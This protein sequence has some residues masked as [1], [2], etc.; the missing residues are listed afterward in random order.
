M[1]PC[2]DRLAWL[3]TPMALDLALATGP[4]G[5][6]YDV[7][8]DLASFAGA[9]PALRQRQD[10]ALSAAA[11][12]FTGGRSLQRSIASRRPDAHCFPS[13]VEVEHYAP[14]RAWRRPRPRPVAGYVGVVDE[15]LDPALLGE[16]A[17]CLPDWDLEVVGPVLKIDEA[18]LPTAP[19][20]RY[21]GPCAYADLPRVM[22]GFDVALMPF[23]S[24]E[25][26][27][28]ISP[29]KTLEYLAAGLPVVS[30]KVPD[31][32]TD[33]GHVVRLADDAEAFAAACREALAEDGEARQRTVAPL[34]HRARWDA[35]A[36]R[37]ASLLPTTSAA[38]TQGHSA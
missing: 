10:A 31:V 28:S 37:M 18:S 7:M 35:I 21:P 30:T 26:T 23:A 19:N 33:F 24:N 12:V 5:V 1:G 36:L 27:R 13:G 34:L 2:E 15:R 17:A 38:A 11:V 20:L 8:D 32:V 6:V 16:L 29:T 25:A 4:R 9:P 3:Y 14:A 22:A